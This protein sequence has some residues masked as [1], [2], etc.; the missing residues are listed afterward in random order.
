MTIDD[1]DLATK[2][3]LSDVMR[4]RHLTEVEGLL[5]N[6]TAGNVGKVTG[7]QIGVGNAPLD[8]LL[9]GDRSRLIELQWR[10]AEDRVIKAEKE[11]LENLQLNGPEEVKEVEVQEPMHVMK[12]IYILKF[13]SKIAG[14]WLR[15]NALLR[16]AK[17]K[18]IG[19]HSMKVKIKEDLIVSV[20]EMG[21]VVGVEGAHRPAKQARR[22]GSRAPSS[23]ATS[24]AG[25]TAG[26]DWGGEHVSPY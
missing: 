24:R 18:A 6:K 13:I 3:E 17:A 5:G 11:R 9:P 20:A 15:N 14:P 2:Y 21:G 22:A 12:M 7:F 26:S 1:V 23:R 19:R 25:S 10:L 4:V 8:Q 16:E